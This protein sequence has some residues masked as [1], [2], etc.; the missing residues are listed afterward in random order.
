M[1]GFVFL[2][3]VH[4]LFYYGFKKDALGGGDIKL[5]GAVGL[6]LGWERL[7]LA[8]LIASVS[9]SIILWIVSR[10]QAA[11]EEV[12]ADGVEAL[13]ER[14]EEPSEE[15]LLTEEQKEVVET[16]LA[17]EQTDVEPND[18]EYPFAPFL[19]VGFWVAL[20]FG[21]EIIKFYLGLLGV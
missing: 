2:Y 6:L 15:V 19:C 20:M 21:A 10:K 16:M 9:A 8:M 7:L 3:G 11:N 14:Q 13:P 5:T 12:S 1:V 4:A 18:K 17:E